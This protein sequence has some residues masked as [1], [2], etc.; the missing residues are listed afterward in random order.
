MVT[1]RKC[2]LLYHYLLI[3]LLDLVAIDVELS[4]FPSS[5]LLPSMYL[6]TSFVPVPGVSFL[7][8][9]KKKKLGSYMV[10]GHIF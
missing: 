8:L 9:K 5:L 3:L 2:M 4:K 10:V 1:I 7:Q 6:K